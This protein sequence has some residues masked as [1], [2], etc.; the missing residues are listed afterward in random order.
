MIYLRSPSILGLSLPRAAAA[1]RIDARF[2]DT[3]SGTDNR[4]M[5][6]RN[7]IRPRVAEAVIRS[8]NVAVILV[9]PPAAAA[10]ERPEGGLHGKETLHAVIGI[11]GMVNRLLLP[12][13]LPLRT[14][15]LPLQHGE[16]RKRSSQ[17]L[18]DPSKVFRGPAS[19]NSFASL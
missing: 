5:H 18:H 19:P 6:T 13:L 10:V 9:R 4:T 17:A 3:S 2:L 16:I 14:R 8:M 15:S 1:A 11:V 12:L 7:Y